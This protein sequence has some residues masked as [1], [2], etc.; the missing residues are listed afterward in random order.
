MAQSLFDELVGLLKQ[1]SFGDVGRLVL[2]V[3]MGWHS[4]GMVVTLLPQRLYQL[5]LGRHA[6]QSLGTLLGSKFRCIFFRKFLRS[7]RFLLCFLHQGDLFFSR[8]LLA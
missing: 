5:A 3:A 8:K 4:A 7:K 2:E 1:A 6:G